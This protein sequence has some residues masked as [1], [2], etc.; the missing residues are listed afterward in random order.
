[1]TIRPHFK[2]RNDS[3]TGRGLDWPV[4]LHYDDIDCNSG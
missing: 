2:D 1:M 4:Y 3:E